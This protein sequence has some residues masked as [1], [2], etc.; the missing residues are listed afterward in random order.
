MKITRLADA[1]A[2]VYTINFSRS[3]LSLENRLKSAFIEYFSFFIFLSYAISS[4]CLFAAALTRRVEE[5]KNIDT[6]EM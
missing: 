5:A 1:V 3:F 2:T 6:F 4:T